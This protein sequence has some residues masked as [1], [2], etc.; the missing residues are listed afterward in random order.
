MKLEDIN[1]E[2]TRLRLKRKEILFRKF[3]SKW[4]EEKE[5]EFNSF[6]SNIFN[7]AINRMRR[8]MREASKPHDRERKILFR[9]FNDKPSY[10]FQTYLDKFLGG[11]L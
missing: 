9:S 10:K 8:Y 1:K 3:S 5:I 4:K 11:K 6:H 2:L 7:E